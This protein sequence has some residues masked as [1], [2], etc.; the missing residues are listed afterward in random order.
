MA[1]KDSEMKPSEETEPLKGSELE[2]RQKELE[3]VLD[4]EFA[5]QDKKIEMALNR[6]KELQGKLMS[7]LGVPAGGGEINSGGVSEQTKQVL[8]QD[9]E[10]LIKQ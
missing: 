4:K 10:E 8:A 5:E 7:K 6:E 1:Q 2:E 3:A 9:L